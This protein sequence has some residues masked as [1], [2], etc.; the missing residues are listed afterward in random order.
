MATA[1]ANVNP[2][3]LLRAF[4]SFVCVDHLVSKQTSE[5]FRPEDT[6]ELSLFRHSRNIFLFIALADLGDCIYMQDPSASIADQG[7]YV[8]WF[9]ES[10]S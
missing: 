5:A 10:T 8:S 2:Y 1:G 6:I 7:I 9:V 3:T 4:Y